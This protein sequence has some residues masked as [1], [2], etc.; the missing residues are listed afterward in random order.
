MFF[1][2]SACVYVEPTDVHHTTLLKRK[3]VRLE[4]QNDEEHRLLELLRSAGATDALRIV[5]CL[6]AGD[7]TQS[8]IDF[9]HDLTPGRRSGVRFS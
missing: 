8:V 4:E 6:R 1:Q 9:A 3:Y 2:K 5:E 7:D